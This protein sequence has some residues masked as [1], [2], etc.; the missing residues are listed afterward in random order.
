MKFDDYLAAYLYENKSLKLEGIGTFILDDKVR[1]LGEQEK[2]AYHPIEGLAFHYNSRSGTDENIII[3]LVKRLGKIEPLIR[4]DLEYYLSNIKQL[5]NIGNPYTIDGIGTLN[6][7]NEGIFEFT[8]G[9]FLHAKETHHKKETHYKKESTDHNYPKKTPSSANR[10]FLII[11]IAV[12]ALSALGGI[13]WGVFNFI[14]NQPPSDDLTRQQGYI[15]TIAQE[16]DTIIPKNDTGTLNKNTLQPPPLTTTKPIGTHSDSV[17]YKMIF[18]ITKSKERA[19]SRTDQLNNLQSYT[20]YDSIPINDSVAYYR[21]FLR[22]KIPAADSARV[23]DS[24]QIFFGQKIF[25][26]K[27]VEPQRH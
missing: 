16:I 27:Q 25:M 21:L 20:Q 12:L 22:M 15:D 10:V 8:P 6:K 14:K 24:L 13:G 3:F 2:E 17:N 1:I 26:E 18:E 19:K 4:S 7:N 11:L 23:K 5:L 9:Y